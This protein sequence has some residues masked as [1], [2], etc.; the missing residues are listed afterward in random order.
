MQIRSDLTDAQA[1]AWAAIGYP[2]TWWTGA[3]R[4]AIAAETRHAETCPLSAGRR[5]ALSPLMVAGD[6]STLGVLP[7]AAVEAVHRMRTDSG[8]LGEGWY[9]RL[10]NDG[11]GEEQYVELVSI[12]AIVSAVDTFR[13]AVGLAALPLPDAKPGTQG[14]VR[15]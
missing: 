9:R 10:R 2:G 13:A 3:E 1:R 15:P 6:H 12:V 7:S 14:K 4:V 11:V 8:R 5:E